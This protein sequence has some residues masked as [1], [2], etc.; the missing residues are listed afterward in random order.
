M[1][2]QNNALQY[3][4]VQENI[5]LVHHN[6]EDHSTFLYITVN[7]SK[8]RYYTLKYSKIQYLRDRTIEYYTKQ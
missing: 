1:T 8:I 5:F 3:I 2:V 4:T 7:H 6:K